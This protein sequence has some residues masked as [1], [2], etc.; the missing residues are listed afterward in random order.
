MVATTGRRYHR[1]GT[2]T[3]RAFAH[4]PLVETTDLLKVIPFNAVPVAVELRDDARSLFS[5]T[6]PR[7]AYYIFGPEDGSVPVEIVSQCRDVVYIPTKYC[8]NLAATVNV[9]LY[10]RACKE[11]QR[12]SLFQQRQ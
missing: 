5:Y 11:A 6:H 3:S 1:A 10:D 2:D 12:V 9:V 4:I 7:S 8:M